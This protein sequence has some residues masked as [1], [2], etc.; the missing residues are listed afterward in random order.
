MLL[1]LSDT[2]IILLIYAILI[3]FCIIV[4]CVKEYI[5]INRVKNV[6]VEVFL[7]QDEMHYLKQIFYLGMSG[8]F[9]IGFFAL[10][11]VPSTDF[12]ILVIDFIV[13]IV[14]IVYI[15]DK[16]P[17]RFILSLLLIPS[18]SVFYLL[19]ITLP[20]WIYI[21]HFIGIFITAIFFIKRFWTYTKNNNLGLTVI[22]FIGILAL[23]FGVTLYSEH[24]T[25][26]DSLVMISNAFTSNGYT[27]LGKTSGG[28]FTSILLVWGGYLLSGVGT[29]TLCAAIINNSFRKKLKEQE[30]EVAFLKEKIVSADEKNDILLNEIKELKDLIKNKE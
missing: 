9:L 25:F 13:A 20:F 19:N 22:I 7:P 15:A 8:L 17:W 21:I 27:V 29:A 28:K 11:L 12:T 3:I 1:N 23:G 26:L 16:R 24:A 10:Y 2:E 14:A 5:F 18:G 4:V 6:D 30:E